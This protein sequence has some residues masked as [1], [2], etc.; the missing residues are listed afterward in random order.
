MLLPLTMALI[1]AGALGLGL[2]RHF[3]IS[4]AL[5]RRGLPAPPELQRLVDLLAHRVGARNPAVR[6]RILGKP[7]A[8]TYGLFRPTVLLSTW[9]LEKLDERELEAVLA[10]EL[11][12][13]A[14][15]DY[16]VVWVATLLRDAFFY[17]PTS[18]MAYC[19]LQQ[20]KET[21]CDDLAVAAT[22]R[23]LSLASA[24]GK[25]WHQAI[26][27]RA[28]ATAQPLVGIRESIA[29]RIERLLAQRKPV[30]TR[31]RSRL[32]SLGIG[33]SG[34]VGLLAVE[35]LSV[36]AAVASMGCG[37]LAAFLKTI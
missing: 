26:G 6:I 31:S 35:A 33:G 13:V 22:H 4:M 9:M 7:L 24:L 32:V 16:P 10:H 15:R 11:A 37:P 28:F 23:P 30:K 5:P 34:L 18:W 29:T 14:R 27:G 21:A 20:E 2:V 25:V 3:V 12:H 17:V 8:V 36:A 19:Q 1:A